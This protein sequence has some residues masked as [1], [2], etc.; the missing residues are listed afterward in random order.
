M[1]INVWEG[2]VELGAGGEMPQKR[3]VKIS[4]HPDRLVF[5]WADGEPFREHW[6]G[7]VLGAAF[8]IV[9]DRVTFV[10]DVCKDMEQEREASDNYAKFK[11]DYVP[12]HV[13]HMLEKKLKTLLRA[14]LL[15]PQNKASEARREVND[16]P[17]PPAKSGPWLGPPSSWDNASVNPLE[18]I[19]AWFEKEQHAEENRAREEAQRHQ[20]Y[21]LLAWLRGVVNEGTNIKEEGGDWTLQRERELDLARRSIRKLQELAARKEYEAPKV[22]K[23]GETR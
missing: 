6:A 2:D 8:R 14:G 22:E 20:E 18:D 5:E 16:T 15:G 17:F 11:K 7:P 1:V 23:I 4:V 21:A 10:Q 13:I 19:K 3:G 12:V 9:M